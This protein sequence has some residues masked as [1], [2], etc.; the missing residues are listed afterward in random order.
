MFFVPICNESDVFNGPLS[1]VLTGHYLMFYSN[2]EARV[3]YGMALTADLCNG[4]ETYTSTQF[5]TP[6]RNTPLVLHLR[7]RPPPI[8]IRST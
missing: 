5:V 7:H 3:S 8:L 6:Y 1:H 4:K 2:T